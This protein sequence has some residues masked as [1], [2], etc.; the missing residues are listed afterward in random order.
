MVE[1]HLVNVFN[2][3]DAALGFI[4]LITASQEMSAS[5]NRHSFSFKKAS[6]LKTIS[7]TR[8]NSDPPSGVNY[9]IFSL[10]IGTTVLETALFFALVAVIIVSTADLADALRPPVDVLLAAGEHS[11]CGDRLTNICICT[12]IKH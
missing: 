9:R 8:D 1:Y 2:F 7:E 10:N 6:T 4:R 3:R 5:R 11:F 12:S